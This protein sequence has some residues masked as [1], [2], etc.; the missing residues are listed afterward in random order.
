[1]QALASLFGD[2]RGASLR[3]T[4]FNRCIGLFAL[5]QGGSGTIIVWGKEGLRWNSTT[6]SCRTWI[7]D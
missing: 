1:M 4:K 5:A 3:T 6:K 2:S 7:Y